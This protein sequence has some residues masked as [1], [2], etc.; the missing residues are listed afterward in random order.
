MYIVAYWFIINSDKTNSTNICRYD[1]QAADVNKH[2]TMTKNHL[3]LFY[4]GVIS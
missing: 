3:H 2:I 4:S 1:E